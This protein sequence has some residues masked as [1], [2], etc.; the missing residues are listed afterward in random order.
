MKKRWVFTG[1]TV[2]L[3][4]LFLAGVLGVG[5]STEWFGLEELISPESA[6]WQYEYQTTWDPALDSVDGLQI[7]WGNGPVYIRVGEGNMVT[8]TEFST[9]PLEQEERFKLVS[10]GGELNVQW[11]HNLLSLSMFQDLEK[12]LV[13]ELPTEIAS[14]LEEL[15]CSNVSGNVHVSEVTAQ[16]ASITSAKGDVMLYSVQGEEANVSTVS[17][18]IQWTVGKA[19]KL[20]A[21]TSSGWLRLYQV[22]AKECALSS[23]TGDLDF[24]GSGETFAVDNV[25]G[26]VRLE[27]SACPQEGDFRSASGKISLTLPENNGFEAA[28]SSVSGHFSSDFPGT[29][30]N[31]SLQYGLGTG[32]LRFT[33]TSGDMA[34]RR[35]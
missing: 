32:K 8:V 29:G 22:Q 17:G 11:D 1:V 16:K 15:R 12:R 7:A 19:E 6:D 30:E 14:Q 2:F 9:R 13:V 5:K 27:L 21:E 28:Y 31:G 26:P 25:S 4:A 10:S 3:A 24:Q 20:S 33:T 35:K 23:V 34:V 18:D